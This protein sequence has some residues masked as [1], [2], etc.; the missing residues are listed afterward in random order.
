MPEDLP[1]ALQLYERV[2]LPRARRVVLSARERGKDN[3]LASPWAALKRD[4]L[5][6]VR[7][8]FGVD[9]TGRGSAWIFEYDVA[10][11]LSLP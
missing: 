2:R 5:I 10:S 1:A 9:R 11:A 8:R 3:H 4:A 7:R 6:A